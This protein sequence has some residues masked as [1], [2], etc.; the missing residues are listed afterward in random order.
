MDSAVHTPSCFAVV[1]QSM[2]TSPPPITKT[3]SPRVMFS[4]FKRASF[5][6]SI[7]LTTPSRS[8]PGISMTL[9]FHNPVPTKTAS[10]SAFNSSKRAASIVSLNL[11]VT[12]SFSIVAISKSTTS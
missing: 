2:A 10:Y 5:K 4:L 12:P 11:N 8:F 9:D 1:T 3:V 6:K 7:A